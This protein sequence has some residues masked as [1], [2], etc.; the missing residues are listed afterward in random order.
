MSYSKNMEYVKVLLFN[1]NIGGYVTFIF[2]FT[3]IA[4]DLLELGMG[5]FV[6]R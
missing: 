5:I 3:T 2:R 1:V 4:N 6:W